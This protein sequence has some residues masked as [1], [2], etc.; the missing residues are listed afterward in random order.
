MS[1]LHKIIADVRMALE[2][3]APSAA[4][5]DHTAPTAQVAAPSTH[6]LVAQFTR[7]VEAVGG[8]CWGW[9]SRAGLNDGVTALVRSDG[10]RRIVIGAPVTGAIP[11]LAAALSSLGAEVLSV[12]KIRGDEQRAAVREALAASDLGIIEADYA[13]AATGTLCVIAAAARPSAL[14]LLPPTNLI[15]IHPQRILPTLADVIAAIGA[16]R[17][18]RHRVAFITGPSRTADIEKMIV[19][20]VHGPKR[21]ICAVVES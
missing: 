20:G 3:T 15:T 11:G 18:A 12:E 4:N 13:I 10:I 17:F 7:E 14:T 9:I 8:V 19:V 2:R 5:H 16:E 21:L 6:A 1:A